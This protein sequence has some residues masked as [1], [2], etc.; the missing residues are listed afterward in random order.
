MTT[1]EPAEVLIS[2]CELP[3]IGELEN[4]GQKVAKRMFCGQYYCMKT[5]WGYFLLDNFRISLFW[6]TIV[7]LALILCGPTSDLGTHAAISK[8]L[9]SSVV[10]F[11]YQ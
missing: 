6:I 9:F 1:N 3:V 11:F 2:T 10:N 5:S 4:K 7:N 8:F